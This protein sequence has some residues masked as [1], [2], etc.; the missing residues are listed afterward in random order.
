MECEEGPASWFH[1]DSHQTW[2]L[3]LPFAAP[4]VFR[5][6]DIVHRVYLPEQR[7]LERAGVALGQLQLGAASRIRMWACGPS[8]EELPQHS[9]RLPA[10]DGDEPRARQAACP[11][12]PQLRATVGGRAIAVVAR[13]GPNGVGETL[14]P[15]ATPTEGS[16]ALPLTPSRT[17]DIIVTDGRLTEGHPV[18]FVVLELTVT[19]PTHRRP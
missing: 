3:G 9:V 12:G 19:P 17:R 16:R 4:S 8:H 15:A 7:L 5:Q 1:P 11:L 6:Q 13:R 18:D 10:C 14:P 2:P